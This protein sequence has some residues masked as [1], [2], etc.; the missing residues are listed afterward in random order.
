MRLTFPISS[1]WNLPI[2]FEGLQQKCQL[3]F[4]DRK[5]SLV[6][7]VTQ[8]DRAMGRLHGELLSTDAEGLCP[9]G[10]LMLRFEIM[11]CALS[12][13]RYDDLTRTRLN[14]LLLRMVREDGCRWLRQIQIELP[15]LT[16]D[17]QVSAHGSAMLSPGPPCWHGSKKSLESS[18]RSDHLL[19]TED[20]PAMP[21]S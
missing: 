13:G 16:Q 6:F 12:L 14:Q 17:E 15:E 19:A 11:A 1:K 10:S 18:D 9:A 20:R 4:Y 8:V 21:G 5:C 7:L 2:S 3:A